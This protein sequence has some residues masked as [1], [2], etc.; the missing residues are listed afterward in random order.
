MWLPNG[1]QVSVASGSL[2]AGEL[3][4]VPV[5]GGAPRAE[6]DRVLRKSARRVAEFN[7]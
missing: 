2:L 4:V 7:A 1:R 3:R 5:G 6:L